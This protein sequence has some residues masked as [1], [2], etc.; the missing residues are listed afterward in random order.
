MVPL[1][2]P[3]VDEQSVVEAVD[4]QAS[5]VSQHHGAG[6]VGESWP[7]EPLVGRRRPLV[8]RVRHR[9]V[10]HHCVDRVGSDQGFVERDAG[11]ERQTGSLLEWAKAVAGVKLIPVPRALKGMFAA[12]LN[13]KGGGQVEARAVGD[14]VLAGEVH[15][16]ES[17]GEVHIGCRPDPRRR[18][19]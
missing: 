4:D 11:A 13:F 5:G 19:Q 14:R 16:G 7:S 1:G 17:R 12:C 2:G 6:A 3:W 18:R 9:G 15:V 8:A 10:T